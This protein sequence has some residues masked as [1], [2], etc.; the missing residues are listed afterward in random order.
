[1]LAE[2]WKDFLK[3]SKVLYKV[4]EENPNKAKIIVEPLERGFGITVGNTL[5]RVLLS[6]IF[7]AAFVEVKIDNVKMKEKHLRSIKMN[8]TNSPYFSE[9]YKII[10]F[11]L[12]EDN[13]MISFISIEIVKE[14]LLYLGYKGEIILS[15]SLPVNSKGS[16]LVLDLCKFMGADQYL[17]GLG[18]LNYLVRKDF[19][20]SGIEVRFQQFNLPKYRQCF[21]EIGFISNLSILDL[22][23][24]K[25]KKSIDVMR[26]GEH[27]YLEWDNLH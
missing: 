24:N 23:F 21:P 1:M 22:L 5:R 18:G 14:I 7:G 10:K 13:N 25:G 4:D 16:D 15:S 19:E 12:H 8:Y 17:S 9:I 6:S 26:S 27:D 20:R 3:P 2:N 11:I